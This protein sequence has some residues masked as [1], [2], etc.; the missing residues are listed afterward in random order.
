MTSSCNQD[1]PFGQMTAD[2]TNEKCVIS[3]R[4]T[5][6][7]WKDCSAFVSLGAPFRCYNVTS[8]HQDAAARKLRNEPREEPDSFQPFS[9]RQC[10]HTERDKSHVK[11]IADL[12]EN[13][14]INPFDQDIYISSISPLQCGFRGWIF[15]VAR[16]HYSGRSRWWDISTTSIP[17]KVDPNTAT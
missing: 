11:A 9:L 17:T 16:A 4:Q 6:G 13:D 2:Q 3:D 7:K 10:S 1:N 5:V 8:E 14:L 15:Q 12:V